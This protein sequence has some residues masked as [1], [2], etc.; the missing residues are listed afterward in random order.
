MTSREILRAAGIA[1]APRDALASL[2]TT[3][4]ASLFG[5]AEVGRPGYEACAGSYRA[6]LTALPEARP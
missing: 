4:E 6:V 5:G 3:V 1:G 2:V